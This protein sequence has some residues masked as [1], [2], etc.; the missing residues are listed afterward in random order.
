MIRAPTVAQKRRSKKSN[1]K[2][3]H[4][5]KQVFHSSR[6]NTPKAERERK[7][8]QNLALISSNDITREWYEALLWMCHAIIQKYVRPRRYAMER[9]LS[10]KIDANL[11]RARSMK[12]TKINVE[13]QAWQAI[14]HN[15]N[16]ICA[17]H[18]MRMLVSMISSSHQRFLFL[19]LFVLLFSLI[20]PLK[21]RLSNWSGKQQ[22]L[23]FIWKTLSLLT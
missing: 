6:A 14:I 23:F 21:C 4:E 1:N 19:F 9:A 22:S 5:K 15:P 18:L 2:H 7:E 10:I 13:N 8:Y 16:E 3:P 20:L 12:L 17:R 11:A